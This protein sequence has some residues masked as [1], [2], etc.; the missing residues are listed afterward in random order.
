MKIDNNSTDEEINRFIHEKVMGECWHDLVLEK[1]DVW[2][3]NKTDCG[4]GVPNYGGMLGDPKP[5]PSYASD[6][7]LAAKVEARVIEKFSGRNYASALSDL[8]GYESN[9]IYG[10]IIDYATA[11]ARQRML[12]MCSMF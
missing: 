3:C 6:L 2:R 7:N 12:A 9:D 1:D 8:I 10:T 4:I 11:T 5:N